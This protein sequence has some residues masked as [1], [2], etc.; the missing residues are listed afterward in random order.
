MRRKK[1]TLEQA[2]T[3]ETPYDR[4]PEADEYDADMARLSRGE[5]MLRSW[6]WGAP[7]RGN[8]AMQSV[9]RKGAVAAIEGKPLAACPYEDHRT[10]RGGVTFSRAFQRSWAEGWHHGI[11]GDRNAC[12]LTPYHDG[13]CKL[14]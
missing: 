1:L 2:R 4:P 9:Y 14:R 13:K 10:D 6:G 11:Y 12:T 8:R 5:R 7:Y 3:V